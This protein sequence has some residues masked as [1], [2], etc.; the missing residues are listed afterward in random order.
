MRGAASTVD[1][2]IVVLPALVVGFACGALASTLDITWLPI[3]VSVTC[4]L[5]I[6]Q[7]L[8]IARAFAVRSGSKGRADMVR[9]PGGHARALARKAARPSLALSSAGVGLAASA[10]F[11][12]LTPLVLAACAVGVIAGTRIPGPGSVRIHQALAGAR[13]EERVA[14]ALTRVRDVH[15]VLNSVLLGAGGDLDHAVVSQR[16]IT[17]V[18]TKHGRGKLSVHDGKVRAGNRVIPG[19]PI[20]QVRRQSAALARVTGRR[21]SSVVCVPDG[22][23]IVH[24]GDVTICGL[25]DL[26]TCLGMGA[27]LDASAARD[28]VA[29]IGATHRRQEQS[30]SAA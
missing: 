20:A 11:Y 7:G 18:E 4:G 24:V 3:A 8:G 5:L 28:L 22:T 9:T 6:G 25:R 26:G 19:D 30:R 23:G 16:G 2:M 15:V 27:V 12:T 14:Y 21:V 13:A 17:A 29:R 1:C 10:V